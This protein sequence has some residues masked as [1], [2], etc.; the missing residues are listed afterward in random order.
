MKP[1]PEGTNW[2]LTEKNPMLYHRIRQSVEDAKW[3]F[4]RMFF[5]E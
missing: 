5:V 1:Q 3:I 2:G 4:K